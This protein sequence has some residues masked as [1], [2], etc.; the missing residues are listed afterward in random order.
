[1][2]ESAQLAHL[3]ALR[4]ASSILPSSTFSQV[5]ALDVHVHVPSGAA[6]KDG[7]SAGISIASSLLSLYL[8]KPPRPRTALSGEVTL[9]GKVLPVGGIKEKA[10]GTFLS[11]HT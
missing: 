4:S 2:R 8:K 9:N 3:V 1:M 7:P 6:P 5:A 10:I 11:F